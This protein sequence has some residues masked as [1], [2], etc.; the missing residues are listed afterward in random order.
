MQE[1]S[2]TS[3]QRSQLPNNL[4]AYSLNPYGK[5]EAV[6]IKKATFGSDEIKYNHPGLKKLMEKYTIPSQ[7][8]ILSDL[9]KALILNKKPERDNFEGRMDPE[10][11]A[12]LTAEDIAQFFI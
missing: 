8:A 6:F 1:F 12:S 4:Q 10:E 11:L 3:L 9:Y 5:N 2:V 7:V